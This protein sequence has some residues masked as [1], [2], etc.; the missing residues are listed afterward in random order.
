MLRKLVHMAV[1][2]IAFLLRFLGPLWSAACA[3]AAV[4][5][6]VLLL[7]RVGG[8]KLWREA[9]TARGGSWGIVLY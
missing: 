4:L 3:L 5:F 6:N 8:K 1:G 2:G 7:P 9:E